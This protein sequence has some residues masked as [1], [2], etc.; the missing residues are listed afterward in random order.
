MLSVIG[1][2]RMRVVPFLIVKVLRLN[3]A[4]NRATAEPD[5]HTTKVCKDKSKCLHCFFIFP[6]IIQFLNEFLL[7]S[8]LT[9]HSLFSK[10]RHFYFGKNGCKRV[11]RTLISLPSFCWKNDGW[12]KMK[13]S[14]SK[15]QLRQVF[16]V[17]RT[18]FFQV[19]V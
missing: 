3:S 11:Q 5:T 4:I 15:N 6:Y 19:T 10:L 2:L 13:R 7:I 16:L 1:N 14:G 12:N 17:A 9:Y 18:V 8:Q